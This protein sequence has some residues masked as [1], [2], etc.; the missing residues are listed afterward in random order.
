MPT[1][2]P[3]WRCAWRQ[4]A[5]VISLCLAPALHANE[6]DEVRALLARGEPAAALKRA[7]AGVAAQP[8]D[9]QLRFVLGVALMDLRRDGEALAH[10]N[11]M[12]QDYPELPDPHNNIALL[13]ARA[14]SLEMARQALETA[15]RNDPGHRTARINL[16]QV[17]LMLAVQAFEAASADGPL[18]A[19]LLRRL[20]A[21]RALLAEALPGAR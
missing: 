6:L 21:V 4:A 7:E 9:A 14:G 18:D 16:G 10:F 1:S 5:L 2:R 12:A 13:H 15:L 3:S 8:R 19:P 20:E 11:R 17:H